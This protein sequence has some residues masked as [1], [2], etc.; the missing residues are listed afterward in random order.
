LTPAWGAFETAGLSL[1]KTSLLTHLTRLAC[2]AVWSLILVNCALALAYPLELEA[3][4]GSSWL[5]VLAQKAGVSLYDH[6]RVAF[7]NMNHGPLD[8]LLKYW[9]S[10]LVPALEP[11]M[12]TRVFVLVFPCL[13]FLLGWRCFSRREV[14]VLLAGVTYLLLVSLTP[15]FLLLG[16][17]DPAAL[18]GL[19]AMLLAAWRL[20]SVPSA[21]WRRLAVAAVLVGLLGG[22]VALTNWRFLPYPFLVLGG[23]VAERFLGLSPGERLRPMMALIGGWAAGFAVVPSLILGA[24]FGGDIALYTFHFFFIFMAQS[25]WGAGGTEFFEIVPSTLRE[26]SQLPLLCLVAALAVVLSLRWKQRSLSWR[27]CVWLAVVGAAWFVSAYAYR[28]NGA[29]GGLYYFVP[30][31]LVAIH[32]VAASFRGVVFPAPPAAAAWALLVLAVVGSPVRPIWNQVTQLWESLP[33][34]YAFRTQVRSIVG[35]QE[36]YSEDVQFLKTA[37]HG[38]VID[39]GDLVE[40][41]VH[42]LGSIPFGDTALRGFERVREGNMPYIMTAGVVGTD[43]ILVTSSVL[44]NRIAQDYRPVV[45][46]GSTMF[47]NYGSVIVLY[48]PKSP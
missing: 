40:R 12:V 13:L 23:L 45:A 22:A 27:D 11:Q 8:P 14:G 47:A 38:E 15:F 7:L 24:Q 31:F 5:H 42:N 44:R 20:Q 3:R 29:G 39:M 10:S 34:A 21:P 43:G 19:C 37:Y 16:R 4:E 17:S 9:L 30:A 41:V 2:V 18:A 35:D 25:G 36:L 28:R 46:S 6:D 33:G 26:T 1:S 32:A 48:A